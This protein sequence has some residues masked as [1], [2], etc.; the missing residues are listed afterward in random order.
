[1]IKRRLG[2]CLHS[3]SDASSGG[4]SGCPDIFE[5]ENGDIAVIGIR[6][7]SGL[8]SHLPADAGCGP[9]EDIVVLPR[10]LVI[11]AAEDINKLA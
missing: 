5:L 3:I 10:S 6:A 1:M 11:A 8:A 9:D 2:K 4:A 7:T